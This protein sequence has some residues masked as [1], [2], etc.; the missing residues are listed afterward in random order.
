MC[1][2]C[3]MVAA[4]LGR[5]GAAAANRQG[6][7]EEVAHVEQEELAPSLAAGRS[8]RA[9]PGDDVP[10]N[11]A[12]AVAPRED[13]FPVLL[14]SMPLEGV[15]SANIHLYRQ[16]SGVRCTCPNLGKHQFIF[17]HLLKDRLANTRNL[18][19][20]TN[21]ALD[22]YKCAICSLGIEETSFH[23]F[24]QCP[25][26]SSCWNYLAIQCNLNLPPLDMVIQ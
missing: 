20:R 13:G 6:S 15:F 16:H 21:E 25:F 1:R 9:Q 5:E 3:L 18:L 22:D 10:Y 23:L 24:F 8:P 14:H 7:G 26:S 17:W 11:G 4:D 2:C 12:S 19:R